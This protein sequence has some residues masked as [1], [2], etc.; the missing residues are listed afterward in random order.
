MFRKLQASGLT[1]FIP[2]LCTSAI[3]SQSCFLVHL[4]SCI[5]Q[6]LSNHRGG[7]AASAGLQ[8]WE[9]L[10]TLGGQKLLMAGIFLVY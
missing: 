5:S 7:V 3:W 1:E 8:V 9:P 4:A 6:L 2:F 10:F